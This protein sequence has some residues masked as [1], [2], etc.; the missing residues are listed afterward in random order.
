VELTGS[1]KY[2]YEQNK[3]KTLFLIVTHFGMDDRVAAVKVMCSA[4]T[5]NK[6]KHITL[7]VNPEKGGKPVDSNHIKEWTLT[8]P[9]I[10]LGKPKVWVRDRKKTGK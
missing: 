8:E 2:W 1:E 3:D 9:L 5:R 4:P 6:H 10:L 7:G